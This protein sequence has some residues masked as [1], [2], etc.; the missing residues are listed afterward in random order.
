MGRI[1]SVAL[2]T[3]GV[4]KTTKTINLSAALAKEGKKVLVVD[5]D[6]QANTTSGL[7]IEVDNNQ[8][9][10]YQ[11][12][13]GEI[14]ADE[15]ILRVPPEEVDIL[16]SNKHLAAIGVELADVKKGELKLKE[17]LEEVRSLYDYVIIDCPPALSFLTINA[18]SASEG[19][20]IPIQSEYYALEGLS[21]L[22]QSINLIRQ[23]IN[24]TLDIEGIVLTMVDARNKL[25]EEVE[26]SVMGYFPDKLFRTKIPRNV[27]LAEAPSYGMSVLRY[28]PDAP[29][30]E[31]YRSLA[32]E[33]IERNQ[34][35]RVKK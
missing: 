10:V 4:G 17:S 22:I 34:I 13:L 23:R 21:L 11:V 28:A 7:G 27:R 9:T 2:Q 24:P 26:K 6:P 12:L 19:V 3:G 1:I 29:G 8:N 32:R 18:F 15:C 16:P 35:Q 14:S 25:S 20:L 30:T 31:A 33:L 5:M